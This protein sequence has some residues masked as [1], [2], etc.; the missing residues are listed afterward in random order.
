MSFHFRVDGIT[1]LASSA[2][3]KCNTEANSVGKNVNL[4]FAVDET[5][6]GALADGF[7]W[8]SAISKFS[9]YSQSLHECVCSYNEAHKL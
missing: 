3:D 6:G 4:L 1:L 8:V 9:S 2:L 5:T 7:E